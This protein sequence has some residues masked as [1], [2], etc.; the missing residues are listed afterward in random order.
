MAISTLFNQGTTALS[1]SSAWIAVTGNNVANVN[2]EGY[3]RQYVVQEDAYALTTRPGAQGQGVNAKVVLRYYDA[4]LERSYVEQSSISSRWSEQKTS[5]ASLENLFNESNRSGVSTNLTAFFT[6]WSDLALRP[7]DTATRQSLLSYAENMADMIRNTKSSIEQ[8][9]SA[10]NVS[11]ND[12]VDRINEISTAIC[13]LNRQITQNTVKDVSVPNGLYDQR[14][15][16]VREMATL[17]DVTT[18]DNGEGKFCVL[19]KSGRPLVDGNTSY[20]LAVMG[21]TTQKQLLPNSTYQGEIIADGKDA[22]EYTCEIVQGGN[23]GAASFRVSLDGGITWLRNEDGTQMEFPITDS[24]GDGVT[25]P[26]TVKNLTISFTDAT[27][28]SQG[29]KFSVVPKDGLYWIEPTRGPENIT[30]QIALNGV[31]NTQRLT[32][33]ALTS[34]Y[35]VR[36]DNCGRY[37]DELNAVSNALIWEVNRL[38]SQGGSLDKLD[39]AQGTYSVTDSTAPLGSARSGL[40]YASKLTAGNVTFNLYDATTGDF[41]KEITLDF[42]TTTAGVQNFDPTE[43]SLQDVAAAIKIG[44]AHV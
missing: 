3:S 38:H 8:I 24:D 10:M 27:K 28:F 35:N 6:A 37:L 12:S 32:G 30:P 5:M 29:D 31:D 15:A 13:D 44:R 14:D 40:A 22:Y 42:D 43:H 21:P 11:I 16:L 19:T 39:Y 23:A 41:Q 9:Q 18:I 7:D 1:A 25:D 4:F 36:D 26:V 33:G 20:E 2:T 17:V 34:Y